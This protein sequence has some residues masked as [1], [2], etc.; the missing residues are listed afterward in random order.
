MW[1]P[2]RP[3]ESKRFEETI[4]TA[5]SRFTR[6][7][8]GLVDSAFSHVAAVRMRR[9]VLTS[10]IVGLGLLLLPETAETRFRVAQRARADAPS[11]DESRGSDQLAPPA[12]WTLYD[13]VSPDDVLMRPDEGDGL[14]EITCGPMRAGLDQASQAASWESKHVGPNQLLQKKQAGHNV[15]LDDEVAYEGVYQGEGVLAKAWF[16]RMSDRLY[17]F[18]GVFPRDDFG[19]GEATFNQLIQSWTEYGWHRSCTRLN[20]GGAS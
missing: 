6:H 14:I 11:R 4:M 3:S 12:G 1:S 2:S 18:L 19:R 20:A 8:A 16:V 15:D 10:L 5:P 9:S 17:V 13:P 7:I